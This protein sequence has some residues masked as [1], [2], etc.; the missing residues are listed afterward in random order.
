MSKSILIAAGSVTNRDVIRLVFAHEEFSLTIVDNGLDAIHRTRELRPDIVLAD[1]AMPGKNGYELCEALK[2]DSAT[3][4]IPVMLLVSTVELL[5][6][7]RATA[8]RANTHVFSPHENQGLLD[9]VKALVGMP[10][11]SSA[12]AGARSIP[13]PKVPVVSQ[14]TE[15]P[16][17]SPWDEQPT[18]ENP[19]AHL[20][21]VRDD[22]LHSKEVPSNLPRPPP[23]PPPSVPRCGP[24][25]SRPVPGVN[26]P[27][28]PQFPML[29]TGVRSSPWEVQET[30]VNSEA[31]SEAKLQDMPWQISA[32]V[33]VRTSAEIAAQGL[34]DLKRKTETPDTKTE[35]FEPQPLPRRAVDTRRVPSTEPVRAARGRPQGVVKGGAGVSRP[36]TADAS[37]LTP[38]G[39]LL[40]ALANFVPMAWRLVVL[41]DLGCSNRPGPAA[42]VFDEKEVLLLRSLLV[43]RGHFVP[44]EPTMRDAM[45]GI[46]ALGGQFKSNGNPGWIVLGRGLTRFVAA[47]T[48]LQTR[49]K[50]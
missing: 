21:A 22:A 39:G 31:E 37:A 50:E 28:I 36:T 48:K 2:N 34:A 7:N 9:K 30:R 18:A 23:P 29:S 49:G 42:R 40:R 43:E 17:P 25:P 26:E 20:E 4:H 44:N 27:R 15:V 5:D 14:P 1:C 6:E 45:L 19:D 10:A 16:P 33:G 47:E 8:A 12:A 46:A 32:Q 41:R 38:N 3:E 11:G 35:E 24:R 13:G